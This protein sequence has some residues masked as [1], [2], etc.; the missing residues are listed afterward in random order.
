MTT[1]SCPLDIV[2]DELPPSLNNIYRTITIKG[3]SRRVLTGA[4]DRAVG[5]ALARGLDVAE[6]WVRRYCH[7]DAL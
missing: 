6:G 1:T 7:F 3:I 4:A 2:L 5:S